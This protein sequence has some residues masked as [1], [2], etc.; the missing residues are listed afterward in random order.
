[1]WSIVLY[2]GEYA[3]LVENHRVQYP[4]SICN[5]FGSTAAHI[6]WQSVNCKRLN[7]LTPNS[8]YLNV[9]VC[10]CV[11]KWKNNNVLHIY[12]FVEREEKKS[13]LFLCTSHFV[14]ILSTVF[15]VYHFSRLAVVC[16][17]VFICYVS[18]FHFL[19]LHLLTF[20]IFQVL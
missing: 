19:V 16:K 13:H 3:T 14:Q 5:K 12:K 1:M 10:V 15:S 18:L 7:V 11:C 2:Q 17:C 20:S 4:T 8:T 6:N 9:S